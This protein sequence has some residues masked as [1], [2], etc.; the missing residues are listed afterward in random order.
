MWEKKM[1]HFYASWAL[2]P[3]G[4]GLPFFLVGDCYWICGQTEDTGTKLQWVQG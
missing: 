1:M 3:W 4:K 2:K